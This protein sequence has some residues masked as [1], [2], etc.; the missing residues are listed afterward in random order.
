MKLT[1]S[2]LD[3]IMRDFPSVKLSYVKNIHKKVS[4]ANIF[5]AIPKGQ[6][7]FAWFRHFKK[8]SVCFFIEYDNRKRQIKSILVK[9]CCFDEKLCINKGTILYGTIV[10]VNNQP[11]FYFFNYM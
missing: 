1:S 10:E 4:S 9:N 8:Y 11:F 2:D 3:Y 7:Y 5:L 6:K